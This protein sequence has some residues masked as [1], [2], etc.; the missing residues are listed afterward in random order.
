MAENEMA[1]KFRKRPVVVDA[2]QWLGPDT[3][4]P[5]WARLETWP[6]EIVDTKVERR[7]KKPALKIETL[8]GNMI[9]QVGDWIIRGVAGEIYPCKPEIFAVTYEAVGQGETQ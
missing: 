6:I 9:A 1:G 4:L 7:S 8:E 3:D 2:V 5:D